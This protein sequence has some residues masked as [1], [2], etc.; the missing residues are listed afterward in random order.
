MKK[1][2]QLLV[3]CLL[4]GTS[5]WSQTS[6][7]LF[8]E[9]RQAFSEKQFSRAVGSFREFISTYP[10][11]PRVDQADYMIGVS[12][13]YLKRF[14]EAIRHFS[15]FENSY[16]GSAYQK[17]IHY[18][19]GISYYAREDFGIAIGE[20][21]SQA[22]YK[23]EIYFLQKSYQFLGYCYEKTLQSDLAVEAYQK[24]IETNPDKKIAAQSLERQGVI[25][26]NSGDYEKALDIFSN[27]TVNYRDI[28]QLLKDI[29]FY[30]G[31]CYFQLGDQDNSI[32][33]FESFLTLYADS[34]NREKAI[35][36][37]GSL[38]ALNNNFESASEYMNLLN[39]EY[40]D[41]EFAMDALIV[42]A[43]GYMLSGDLETARTS[44]QKLLASQTDP[45]EI[46]KIQF[47][48]ART[49]PDDPDKAL[50]W[51]QLASKGQDR[52]IASESLYE[53]GRI[54]DEKGEKS[55][56]ILVY[57]KL[58][59][60]YKDSPQR[61]IAGEWMAVYYD[62]NAQDLAL[63][64]H[65]DRM[66]SD[67]PRTDK[68]DLY[69]YMRGNIAYREH[70]Y[71]GAL[72][73]YQNILKLDRTEI[74]LRNEARYRIGYIYTLRKEFGRARGYFDDIMENSEPGELYYR[75]L[76]SSAICH[77]NITETEEAA[78]L[79]TQ[80]TEAEGSVYWKGDAFF[81]L[82]K[83]AMETGR[84]REAAENYEQA[85]VLASY[86]ERRVQ[87]LYQLGWSYM[88]LSRF[89][90][91]SAQFDTIAREFPDHTLAGD[92]LYRSGIALSYLEEWKASLDRF[93][94]ALEIIEYASLREELLYQ[95]AW[96]HFMLEEFSSAMEY[97]QELQKE[98]PDSPLPPDGLFRAAEA[99]LEQ[100]KTDSAVYTYGQLY[101]LFPD[102][103]LAETSL[104]RAFSFSQDMTEK[105]LLMKEYLTAYPVAEKARLIALQIEDV[106]KHQRPTDKQI[107]LI[108]QI[109]NLPVLQNNAV[110]ELALIFLSLSEE[111]SLQ[112]L[113]DM[114]IREDLSDKEKQ[115][116]ELYRGIHFFLHENFESSETFLRPLVDS[117]IPSI[118]AQGQFYLAEILKAQELWK[119]A[120]DAYLRIK[121]RFPDQKL[122][123][124]RG[125]YQA[126]SAYLKADDQVSSA[127]TLEMMT[128]EYPDSE[129]TAKAR[130]EFESV[131]EEQEPLPGEEGLLEP[132][133]LTPP[134]EI[135]PELE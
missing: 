21:L 50:Q 8:Q 62:E 133:L 124:E 7:A 113:N 81:Y 84:Y 114:A 119:S 61:E 82:G 94:P 77:L 30:M 72:Q 52:A 106:L 127:S 13:F 135:L 129:W 41:S 66:L 118:A 38:Y 128:S 92:S 102:S 29:P 22:E 12:Y 100:G 32:Q 91:A 4:A 6:T 101:Y 98:F 134:E 28:P 1:T 93:L 35:F 17:R 109:Q 27:L 16:P 80:L 37:L 108:T 3:F 85:A 25:F 10:E 103:P 78:E 79:F 24:L 75:A 117:E 31:E 14:D 20:F 36:R 11:D 74:S 126:V 33:K 73:Y 67:Y 87:S 97:L 120:A 132:D 63:K 59:N 88:R 42:L 43:E 86:P 47:N 53:S 71:N 19:K 23:D 83:I 131:I 111:E 40:P 65:L 49:W 45:L 46:Q 116:V 39:S 15:L 18:W 99:L 68:K 76:L 57:E 107:D 112:K 34:E 58:F 55:R 130:E 125:L 26:M 48:L 54:Y 89:D 95:I 44:L 115:T 2:A 96:S 56:T 104:F 110:I 122:W 90:E 64:N 60:Q 70:D 69:L 123:I 5:L 51:Y 105:F 9:A 121:Y